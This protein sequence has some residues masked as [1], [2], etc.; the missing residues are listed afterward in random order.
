MPPSGE[1]QTYELTVVGFQTDGSTTEEFITTEGLSN[2]AQ[3]LARLT[4]PATPVPEQ[5]TLGLLG[6]GILG[7]AFGRRR[8]TR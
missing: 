2:E 3:L 8:P 5:L 6:V 7:I 1:G 4:Q